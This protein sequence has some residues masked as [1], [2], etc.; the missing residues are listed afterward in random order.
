MATTTTT[1]K[2]ENDKEAKTHDD[3][4]DA[5]A[6]K[7]ASSGEESKEALAAKEREEK[8]QTPLDANY[9]TLSAELDGESGVNVIATRGG[10]VEVRAYIP[11]VEK[12]DL[13][14]VQNAFAVLEKYL[15]MNRKELA[16][17]G[18]E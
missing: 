17:A 16:E 3:K 13:F 11:L 1:K 9:T 2:A 5:E 12:A 14:N 18:F 15:S 6:S 4:K 10:E 7:E 8:L